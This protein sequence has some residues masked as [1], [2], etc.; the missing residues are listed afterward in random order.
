V[1]GDD[2][3]VVERRKGTLVR[4]V[5]AARLKVASAITTLIVATCVL[6]LPAPAAMG[7]SRASVWNVAT[8]P[9]PT[10]SWFTV[11]Y[12][13]SQWVALGDASEVAVSPNGLNWTEYPV[14]DGSWHSV[15]YGDGH[16]VALSSVNAA[17]EEMVSTMASTGAQLLGLAARGPV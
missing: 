11:D 8:P 5:P 10:G 1:C 6:T 4:T 9:A 12:A 13:D 14:P 16:F 15:A 3:R 17:L 7:S 2:V